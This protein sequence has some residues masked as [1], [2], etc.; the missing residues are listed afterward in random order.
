MSDFSGAAQIEIRDVIDVGILQQIQDAFSRAIDF[1]AMVVD[2]SGQ[3]VTAPSGFVSLCQMIRSTEAGFKRCM[4]CD[5]T[6]GRE[7]RRKQQPHVYLCEGGL[8]DIAAPIVVEGEYLASIH[9]G[10]VV[11]ADAH[12]EFVEGM[13]RR[14][15]AL[16]LPKRELRQAIEAVPALPRERIDAAATLL[17]LVGNYLAEMGVARLTKA[18][19]L[20]EAENRVACQ[21]E[22]QRAER[23]MLESQINSHFL[24]NALGLIGYTAIQERAPQTEEIAYCLSDLLRYG[25]RDGPGMATL[26]QELEIIERYLAIQKL[27]FGSRLRVR[28]QV[29]P[30]L[31][32]VRIPRL[33][34]QPLLENVVIHAVETST[35][36]V[37]VQVRAAPVDKRVLRIEVIDDG[38]GMEAEILDAIRSRTFVGK[39]GRMALGLRNVIRRLDLEYGD[40]HSFRVETESGR[41]TR[42]HLTLPVANILSGRSV[43]GV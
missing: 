16:R 42:V 17:F 32:P 8:I 29:E 20:E 12:E 43:L 18:R 38:P 39:S 7:S 24:F 22:L 23:S 10:Q 11:P 37:T 4:G 9:C 40:K 31:H 6:G 36:P 33:I 14:N 1:A 35:R 3:P 2:P 19:L 21:I 34:L 30:S 28:I 15:S 5:L 27:R 41:G 13:L 26:G 25:L